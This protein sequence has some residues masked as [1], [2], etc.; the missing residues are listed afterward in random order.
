VTSYLLAGGGTAGHVNPL[1]AVAT[2]IRSR[3][4][5]AQIL[6][7]GTREGLES[8]L[9]PAAGFEIEYIARLPFPRRPDARAWRF[10]RGWRRTVDRVEAVIAE[11]DIDVV[12]G[13]GGY[14]AA[15]V[16]AAARRTGRPIVIHEANARP[17][18]AN[19]WAARFARAVG[20]AIRGTKI[21]GGVWVGMPLRS[22]ISS[23]NVASRRA[24]ARRSFGLDPKRPVLL[25]TGGSLGARRI[26][27]VVSSTAEHFLAA[28]WQILHITGARDEGF[29]QQLGDGHVVMAYCN[30]MDDALAA[31]TFAISRA[32]SSTVAE[33]SALGI[34]AL[35]VPYA[36]GN[37][38]Q[39]LN[40]LPLA[41]AGGC[42]TIDDKHFT[43]EWVTA[44]LLPLL[45][46]Q[47]ELDAMG[48]ASAREGTRDGTAR[49]VDLIGEALEQTG[50]LST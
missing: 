43:S 18:L 34:P 42:R 37:G 27:A 40:A 16:Y 14:V 5:H 32:G 3:D 45:R 10:V 35:L 48:T 20:F 47:D 25:V 26:N 7:I 21:R 17:G 2:E 8:Q 50:S 15:P 12:F 39:A 9:V 28:G 38:E 22:S 29:V 31:A 44:N 11:H 49:T 13:V 33:L 4:A 23:L 19:R 41:A 24:Q 46:N 1:L 36:S 30:R 6:F